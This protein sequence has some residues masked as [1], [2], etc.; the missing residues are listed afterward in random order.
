MIMSISNRIA[1][2]NAVILVSDIGGGTVPNL[3][4]GGLVAST[5]S[6]IAVGCM[7]DC[8]GQTELTLGAAN[9]VGSRE[10]P[11][12]EGELTTPNH[13]VAVRTVLDEIILQARV[14]HS[15]T[16][17]RIWVNHPSEPDKVIIGLH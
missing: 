7:S 4:R 17:V 3:I 11:V 10:D 6:C 8:N 5:P 14:L 2:P 9:E 1:V 16:K 15:R 12:F 13:E